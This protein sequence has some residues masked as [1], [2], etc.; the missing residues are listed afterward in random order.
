MDAWDEALGSCTPDI[1]GVQEMLEIS[2]REMGGSFGLIDESYNMPA[3]TGVMA[4]GLGL[5]RGEGGAMRPSDENILGLAND[6][7]ITAVRSVRGVQ[8]YESDRDGNV[9]LFRNMFRRGEDT[10][11]NRLLFS[12]PS[13][14][15]TDTDRFMLEHLG[16][17]IERITRNLSTF[18]IPVSKYAALKELILLASEPD[19]KPLPSRFDALSPLGWQRGEPLRFYLFRSVYDRRDAGVNDYLLRQLEALIPGAC[20][21]VREGQI[22]LVQNT[23]RCD[24]PFRELRSRLAEF[25]RENM[26][27]A[28]ISEEAPSFHRLRGA[29]MQAR[30]ALELGS[31][32]DP[33][34]WYYLFENYLGDYLLRKAA[35][36]IPA[37]MLILPP[38]AQLRAH[39]AARATQFT[40][41]L[42][43]L[44]EEGFNITHAARRLYIHRTSLQ[45]RMDRIRA[46]TGLDLDD[47]DT[48]FLLEFSFRILGQDP[49]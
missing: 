35:E 8:R 20:G 21:V 1:A 2:A 4:E 14:E 48:R 40:R 7:Q 6:P 19:E 42:R 44:C 11:Y 39:D 46:L 3:F 38:V 33:M 16:G 17:R 47:A 5:R 27:K 32:K 12:R 34:F 31:A 36:D 25:L 23:A 28:G 37:D 43:A 49:D 22:L 45:D 41:T 30:A 15:Y 26:Y 10:Y 13:N 24:V 9:S 18:S 29:F